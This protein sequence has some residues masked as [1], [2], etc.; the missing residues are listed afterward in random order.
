MCHVVSWQPFYMGI[1]N[2]WFVSG[3]ALMAQTCWSYQLSN[4]LKIIGYIWI[5]YTVALT[6]KRF[7]KSVWYCQFCHSRAAEQAVNKTRAGKITVENVM[8][9][10]AHFRHHRKI[11]WR[12]SLMVL[13]CTMCLRHI[14]GCN[15]TSDR[16]TD[17]T[18]GT[19][20]LAVDANNHANNTFLTR[21]NG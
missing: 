7:S 19:M 11:F 4:W 1:R 18:K 16:S 12:V 2:K 14:W 17:S 6:I 5:K 13:H 3:A 10:P 15:T 9:P 20:G 21:K 8:L